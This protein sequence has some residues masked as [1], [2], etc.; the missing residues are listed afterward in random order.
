M[1]PHTHFPFPAI[2]TIQSL[3][4]IPIVILGTEFIA[5]TTDAL[6]VLAICLSVFVFVAHTVI[7]ILSLT[8]WW[9]RPLILTADGISKK[10]KAIHLW[11]DACD[12]KWKKGIPAQWGMYYGRRLIIFF[13]DGSTIRFDPN[14]AILKDI[15]ELCTNEEILKLLKELEELHTF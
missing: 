14:E 3:L 6:R 8:I 5:N 13:S 4:F 1:K 12:L 7:F 9:N 2:A 15:Y 10:K 11:S